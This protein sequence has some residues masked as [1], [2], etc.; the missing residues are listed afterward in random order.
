MPKI[1]N[2]TRR[3]EAINIQ[4]TKLR[5]ECNGIE[6]AEA[7]RV[8]LPAA[9]K[10]VGKTFVYRGNSY[11]CPK[12]DERW[13]VYRIVRAYVEADDDCVVLLCEDVQVDYRGAVEFKTHAET[14]SRA[15]QIPFKG[16]IGFEPC[17]KR[18]F[19]RARATAVNELQ[20][21]RKAAKYWGKG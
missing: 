6:S 13:D 3:I 20:N 9:K 18:E 7:R 2:A 8:V 1:D 21:P 14:L 10:A 19:N 17:S 5:Q 12:P 16:G 4:I 15:K 11:S